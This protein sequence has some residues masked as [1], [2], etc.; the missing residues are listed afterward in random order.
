[1]PVPSTILIVDDEQNLRQTLAAILHRSGYQVTTA[2]SVQEAR[3]FLRAC[4]F[5]LVFLDLK[6]P[7]E[8]GNVLL[9]EIH[10]QKSDM[11]VVIMTAHATLNT[12]IKAVH[13]GAR[14]Y[15]LKPIDPEQIL[16]RTQ[17]ILE[18]QALPSRRREIAAQMQTLV[19]ELHQ[20][21]AA[22]LS[23]SGI[24]PARP[25]IDLGRFLRRGS[26]TIDLRSRL[27]TLEGRD[28]SLPPT[29]FNYLLT[30]AKH[31]P[32]PVPFEVLVTESQGYSVLR[33]EAREMARGQIHELRKAIE[34]NM[35]KPHFIITMRDVGYRLVV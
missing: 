7:D 9:S 23:E 2:A 6:M 29:S 20:M 28:I 21:E 14:D 19:D 5:D 34:P 33:Y 15:L 17:E 27:I 31:F 24:N 16:A 12:A 35:S 4:N 3:Q 8:D 10:Q 22:H 18:Q 11:A 26:L 30:L 32:D 13:D 25:D 1:M